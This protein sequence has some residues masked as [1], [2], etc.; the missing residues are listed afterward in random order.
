MSTELIPV[1][2]ALFT[3]VAAVA[4]A[5]AV[6]RSASVRSSL[7]TIRLIND[8][9]RASNV[10]LRQELAAERE[11][12]ARLEGRIDALTSD[13]AERIVRAVTLA[14]TDARPTATRTRKDDHQ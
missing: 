11:N 5:V 14:I 1:S 6:W 2:G 13:L 12:R 8:E 10:E 7:D 4:A 9:L 3:V